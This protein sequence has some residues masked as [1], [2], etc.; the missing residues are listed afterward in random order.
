MEIGLVLMTV[1]DSITVVPGSI[2]AYNVVTVAVEAGEG[3]LASI[4]AII[5]SSDVNV[6]IGPVSMVIKVDVVV[7]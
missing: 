7:V 6:I 2:T 3:T 5:V 4:S 1:V